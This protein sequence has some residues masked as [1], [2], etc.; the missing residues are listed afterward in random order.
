MLALTTQ[1]SQSFES[2]AQYWE[3]YKLKTRQ[4]IEQIQQTIQE[5]VSFM[6]QIEQS[7]VVKRE[8]LYRLDLTNLDNV[9]S[10]LE[11]LQKGKNELDQATRQEFESRFESVLKSVATTIPQWKYWFPSLLLLNYLHLHC[12]L[13]LNIILQIQCMNIMCKNCFFI[14]DFC[15][16][17]TLSWNQFWVNK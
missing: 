11:R 5:S 12:S 14:N 15:E 1:T 3:S 4:E 8:E 10:E 2:E 6:S 7:I 16:K 17:Q 9:F 13:I